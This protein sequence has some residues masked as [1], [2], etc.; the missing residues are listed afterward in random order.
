MIR[1]RGECHT[2]RQPRALK[3]A[4]L[5]MLLACAIACGKPAHCEEQQ[6]GA[7]W[8]AVARSVTI[9]RDSWGVPHVYGPTDASVVFGH[10]YA[11]AED[12]F[13]QIEENFIL[14]T[15]RAAEAH[16]EEALPGDLLVRALEVER[17]SM[18]EYERSAPRLRVLCDAFA[19]GL[20]YFLGRQAKIPETLRTLARL[21]LLPLWTLRTIRTAQRGNQRPQCPGNA[22]R[23]AP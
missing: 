12:N 3:R 11:Q 20:N 6:G 22:E 7:D 15:G 17:L 18:E 5:Q 14:A 16:G 23:V 4:L 2:G 10:L 8:S 19:A 13:W 9:H 21:R 1:V